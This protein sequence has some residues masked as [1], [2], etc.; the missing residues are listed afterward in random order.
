MCKLTVI[1]LN[2]DVVSAPVRGGNF[3]FDPRKTIISGLKIFDVLGL[4]FC[5]DMISYRLG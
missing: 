4:N 2:R 3:R 5:I 1:P